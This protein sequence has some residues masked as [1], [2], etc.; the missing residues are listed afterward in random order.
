M[1][2]ELCIR[3]RAGIV[4][5]LA[6][7]KKE[8]PEDTYWETIIVYLLHGSNTELSKIMESMYNLSR[9]VGEFADSPAM[10]LIRKGRE[11]AWTEARQKIEE[12]RQKEAEARRKVEEIQQKEA[13]TRRKVEEIRQKAEAK[14]KRIARQKAAEAQRKIE[15]ERKSAVEKMLKAGIAKDSIA[16]FLGLSP[17][18]LTAYI[19][20]IQK[21]GSI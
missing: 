11:E 15:N 18:K 19:R 4:V 6:V 12:A 8:T 1:L 17:Q 7:G 14:Q 21:A 3:S 16:E 10:Q 9:E 2:P 5:G 20:Q 13:E